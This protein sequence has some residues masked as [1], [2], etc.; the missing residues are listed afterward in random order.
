MIIDDLH[1]NK[2]NNT[3]TDIVPIELQHCNVITKQGWN[4]IDSAEI[5]AGKLLRKPREKL[6]NVKELVQTAIGVSS[7]RQKDNTDKK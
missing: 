3:T 2:L 1:N 5:T 4:L 7:T 6:N